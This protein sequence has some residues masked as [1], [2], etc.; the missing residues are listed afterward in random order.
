MRKKVR[1]HFLQCNVNGFVYIALILY[2]TLSLYGS[3]WFGSEPE[4]HKITRLLSRTEF[5]LPM[6]LVGYYSVELEAVYFLMY[7][8]SKELESWH[9]PCPFKMYS[10]GYTLRSFKKFLLIQMEKCIFIDNNMYVYSKTAL[11]QFSNSGT[12]QTSICVRIS[13]FRTLQLLRKYSVC[14]SF[15]RMAMKQ[16]GKEKFTCENIPSLNFSTRAFTSIF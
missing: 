5:F 1:R 6:L 4:R 11:S 9:P 15:T 3:M 10:I 7:R 13:S 2:V 16:C 12:G 8:W 14:K